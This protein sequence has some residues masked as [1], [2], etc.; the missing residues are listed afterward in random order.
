MAAFRCRPRCLSDVGGAVR[1]LGDRR[2]LREARRER[3]S[4]D[5]VTSRVAAVLTSGARAAAIG[6]G[7]NH[8]VPTF[9]PLTKPLPLPTI[10]Q[11]IERPV[12]D[13]KV[14]PATHPFERAK[15]VAA[16]ANHLGGT[17]LIGAREL[18]GQ[19][20]AYV[21]MPPTEAGAVRDGYSKAVADRCMPR[22]A[23]DFEEYGDPGDPAKRIVAINVQPSLNLVGV[24]VCADKVREGYGG[25]AYV[26]PVRSG[27]DAR[28]LEPGQLAM[29]MTPHV[30]RVAVL[31]SRIPKGTAVFVRQPRKH[32]YFEFRAKLD[33]VREEDNI[34]LLS[35][36]SGGPLTN[37]PLDRITTVFE[38]PDRDRNM[39]IW[40]IHVEMWN[41]TPPG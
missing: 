16:F 15:D 38:N 14:K 33:E 2:R 4:Y 1:Y 20:Q 13:W 29:F 36:Q 32:D 8:E 21:G 26:F 31:L 25:A 18:N 37:L 7:Y 11:T 27:T 9:I 10:G 39:N 12:M 17:L 3:G 23:I 35:E 41:T 5:R 6:T 34:V 24:E 40:H 19:L 30:R 22:P 28:Y